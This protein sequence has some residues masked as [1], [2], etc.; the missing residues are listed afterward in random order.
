MIGDSYCY[1]CDTKLVHYKCTKANPYAPANGYTRDH[2]R[3]PNIFTVP[4]CFKCNQL[5]GCLSFVEY[6][7]LIAYRRKLI[8]LPADF[9]LPGEKRGNSEIECY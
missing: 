3:L 1:Y 9:K 4:S 2:V 7:I 5:K 6:K 8:G